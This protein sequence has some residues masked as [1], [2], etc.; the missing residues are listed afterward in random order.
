MAGL[1]YIGKHKMILNIGLLSILPLIVTQLF[2]VSSPDYVSSVLKA[3]SVVYGLADM[4]YGIGGL[5]AGL[6]TGTLI[7]KFHDR[8]IIISQFIIKKAD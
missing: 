1:K 8:S 5:I 3:N 7:I 2:N 4:G 6:I